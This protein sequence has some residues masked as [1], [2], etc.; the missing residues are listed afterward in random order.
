MTTRTEFKEAMNVLRGVDE[1]INLLQTHRD[2][3]RQDFADK[4]CPVKAGG[5]T[6]CQ[7]W[8]HQDKPIK[9]TRVAL[10]K[11]FHKYEWLSEEL[12]ANHEKLKGVS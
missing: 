3:L 9:V 6:A 2:R 5:V 12:V 10:R 1:Q 11:G 4:Y 7:G 8:S